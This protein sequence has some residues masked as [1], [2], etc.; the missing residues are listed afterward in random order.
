MVVCLLYHVDR[1]GADC[2]EFLDDC[3]GNTCQN[4]AKCVDGYANYTCSCLHGYTG[5]LLI[6]I[7]DYEK[8]VGKT[9]K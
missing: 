5:N 6:Y 2:T 8:T 7:E 9:N 1:T 4:E 3:V